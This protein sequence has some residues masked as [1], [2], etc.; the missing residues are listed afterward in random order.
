MSEDQDHP[1][2]RGRTTGVYD[3]AFEM[4]MIDAGVFP[5]QYVDMRNDSKDEPFVPNNLDA[6]LERLDRSRGETP[7]SEETFRRFARRNARAHSDM[8]VFAYV[9]PVLAGDVSTIDTAFGIDFD[10]LEPF[11]DGIQHA[12]PDIY[13]GVEPVR[14]EPCV[15]ADLER[16]IILS[17][18]YSVSAAPNHF[19]E[20]QH[21]E[22]SP[23]ALRRKA[24][25]DGAVGAR[26]MFE[27]Q[28]YGR[29]A[30]DK[31]YDGNAYTIVA[32]F[33]ASFAV[34]ALYGSHPRR[35]PSGRTEYY[36]TQLTTIAMTGNIASFRQAI[37]AL[38]NARDLNKEQ[39]EAFVRHANG[40]ARS[41]YPASSWSRS[42]WVL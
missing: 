36:L 19:M 34:L 24:T 28:N 38:R 29:P 3:D 23:E 42:S 26:A 14:I 30:D 22:G 41:I 8:D 20:V 1:A 17:S 5:W 39:R 10:T 13:D 7:V 15:Y 9:Y 37:R 33:H 35:S 31:L 16:Y 25:Y 40:V 12:S 32:L 27:L 6:I 11:Y 4:A 18:Q 2:Q 21:P